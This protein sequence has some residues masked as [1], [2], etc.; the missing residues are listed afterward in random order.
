[1]LATPVLMSCFFSQNCIFQYHHPANVQN[2]GG[3]RGPL[4]PGEPAFPIRRGE[5]A[6]QY[7]LKHGTCKFGQTCKF[8]HPPMSPKQAATVAAQSSAGTAYGVSNAS[9]LPQRPNEPDCIYFLRN[10]RCKYGNTC[11][12]HH[13]LTFEDKKERER[14]RS[15]GSILELSSGSHISFGTLNGATAIPVHIVGSNGLSQGQTHIILN[16]GKFALM[17]NPTSHE[18]TSTGSTAPLSSSYPNVSATQYYSNPHPSS[19]GGFTQSPAFSSISSY[20][21]MD[22]LGRNTSGAAQYPNHFQSDSVHAT[23]VTSSP[24]LSSLTPHQSASQGS[25]TLNDYASAAPLHA[26]SPPRTASL[27]D[28]YSSTP[29]ELGSRS[30][31]PQ[32]TNFHPSTP[33]TA[34][35]S[36]GAESVL[37]PSA[38]SWEMPH[39]PASCQPDMIRRDQKRSPEREQSRFRTESRLFTKSSGHQTKSTTAERG[40]DLT[41]GTSTRRENSEQSRLASSNSAMHAHVEDSETTWDD[42]LSNVS[43][44]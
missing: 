21:T 39:D 44:R 4:N 34:T 19:T 30:L 7:Y 37:S 25:L 42:G 18:A 24:A 40:P 13:P 22:G 15:T 2:G 26:G 28:H 36:W 6:C 20:E 12:Y 11:K 14:S 31:T 32:A 16:D 1:M 33:T 9:V 43:L 5:P 41:W 10:G 3:V 17:L 23:N 27:A 8:N 35:R 38:R 29:F